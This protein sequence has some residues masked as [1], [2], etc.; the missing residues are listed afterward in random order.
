HRR[1]D[2]WIDRRGR[3]AIEINRQSHQ[4]ADPFARARGD[5]A[6]GAAA[7]GADALRIVL[8]F[9]IAGFLDAAARRPFG[10]SLSLA[11]SFSAIFASVSASRD[12][13]WAS[14]SSSASTFSTIFA[15]PAPPALPAAGRFECHSSGVSCIRMSL[16]VPP[17]L[18]LF[19]ANVV[20][21]I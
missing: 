13:C 7:F 14:S 19:G 17:L 12:C 16:N 18:T 15:S 1:K 10:R 4:R 21:S 3:V 9:S 8:V 11:R 5:A 20:M 2:P 6:L